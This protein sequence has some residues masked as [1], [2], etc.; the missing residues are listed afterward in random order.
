MNLH[1]LRKQDSIFSLNL[2]ISPFY[3]Y[4]FLH[5]TLL[6]YYNILIKNIKLII[7]HFNPICVKSIKCKINNSKLRLFLI[8]SSILGLFNTVSVNLTIKEVRID[9]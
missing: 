5:F 1:L 8:N 9:G 4:L 6:H 7:L 2:K 3:P